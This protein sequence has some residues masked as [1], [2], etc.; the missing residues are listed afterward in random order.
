MKKI[1]MAL[2]LSFMCSVIHAQ[3]SSNDIQKQ[4][5]KKEK[6]KTTATVF[7]RAKDKNKTAT[8]QTLYRNNAK[9][10]LIQ[11]KVRPQNPHYL[12]EKNTINSGIEMDIEMGMGMETMQGLM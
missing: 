7:I 3:T 5:I 4:Y 6:E 2:A 12:R 10:K 1:I 8:K 11:R 9:R